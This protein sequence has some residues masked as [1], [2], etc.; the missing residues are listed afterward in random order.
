MSGQSDKV[1]GKGKEIA[2]KLTGDEDME[3]EGKGQHAAGKA[4]EALE[5]AA[6]TAKGAL[7]SL[8]D[9]LSGNDK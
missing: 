5:D 4:K 3:A 9:K 8:K 6:E 7:G 2:G 1:T